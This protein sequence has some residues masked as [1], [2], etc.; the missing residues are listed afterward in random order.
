MKKKLDIVLTAQSIPPSQV[1]DLNIVIDVLRATSVMIT[2]L[3]NGVPHLIPV[4]E[5]DEALAIRQHDPTYLL[6]GERQAKKIAGFDCGNSPLEFMNT[7]QPGRPIVLTTTNGT[8][9][10]SNL[11]EGGE[12][13]VACF[14]NVTKV[15]EYVQSFSGSIQLVCAGTNGHF[16][17]DDFLCAGSII[18]KI[19]PD[20]TLSD[21]AILARQHYQ[22][23]NGDL[24]GVLANCHHY[25][26]LESRGFGADLDFCIRE[27]IFPILTQI[28][29]SENGKL[30][31]S[32]K[33]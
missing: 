26:V 9:A 7:D 18:S 19:K 11:P 17:L 4:A 23:A 3:A 13:Q 29:R 15:A 1:Y 31:I 22:A 21:I 2:A 10:L 6:A 20:Y 24:H 16:S 25:G 28:K 14:L 33:K 12:I 8:L 30:F 32:Q 5:I 27:D